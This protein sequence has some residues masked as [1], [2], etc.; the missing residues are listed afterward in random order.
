M[1]TLYAGTSIGALIAAARVG[2]MPVDEL[3]RAR[4]VAAPARPVPASIISGCCSSACGRRRSISRSRC[5]IL[6]RAVVPDGH[7][8]RSRRRRCS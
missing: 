2:G 6:T 3:A 7:V 5:A 1:P 4:R 8:R